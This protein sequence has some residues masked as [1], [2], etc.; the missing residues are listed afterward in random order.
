MSALQ[1]LDQILRQNTD[2]FNILMNRYID[3][4][5]VTIDEIVYSSNE[6]NNFQEWLNKECELEQ[7]N[8]EIFENFAG[9]LLKDGV[10][11]LKYKSK[12]YLDLNI[13]KI[14]KDRLAI[15]HYFE[16]NGDLL[17]DPDVEFL[18]DKEHKMILPVTYQNDPAGYYTDVTDNRD[19]QKQL[20]SYLNKWFINL[21]HYGHKLYEI[22]TEDNRLEL[23]KNPYEFMQYCK[24]NNIRNIYPIEEDI[25]EYLNEWHGK[26][27]DEKKDISIT[28]LKNLEIADLYAIEFDDNYCPR[29]TNKKIGEIR[30]DLSANTVNIYSNDELM[31]QRKFSSIRDLKINFLDIFCKNACTLDL[32]TE[33]YVKELTK[34]KNFS[35]NQIN[36]IREGIYGSIDVSMYLD[37]SFD[38]YQMHQIRLGLE[39][40]IDVEEYCNPNINWE[41]MEKQ[42]IQMEEDQ[43][44][45]Y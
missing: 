27:F 38:E 20:S 34:D 4:H 35:L 23:S 15:S 30:L 39:N 7:R 42:R 5:K 11:Y 19:L 16:F 37:P 36:E 10:E 40:G 33:I 25:K 18:I 17:A 28:D 44:I 24:K 22:C 8:Y 43:E 41:D 45:N 6:W 29:Q 2:L 9:L 26:Y 1:E 3:E 21:H 31:I 13:E 14:G 32:Q 12:G